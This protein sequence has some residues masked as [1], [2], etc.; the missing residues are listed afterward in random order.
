MN[1]RPNFNLTSDFELHGHLFIS[2]FLLYW[3]QNNQQQK[4]NVETI[5][6]YS[7]MT[8]SLS[9]RWQEIKRQHTAAGFFHIAP[10]HKADS[11][12]ST[13]SK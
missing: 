8:H 5:K 6:I 13:S 2:L 4:Q 9:K 12:F 10:N 3:L 1:H 7:Q 11:A